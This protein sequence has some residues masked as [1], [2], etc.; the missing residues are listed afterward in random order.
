MGSTLSYDPTRFS[1]IAAATDL[2]GCR[3]RQDL[4]WGQL[5]A[6][7]GHVIYALGNAAD[8]ETGIA[9]HLASP[10]FSTLAELNAFCL[11]H[12]QD[13]ARTAERVEISGWLPERWFWQGR[14]A[15]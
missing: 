2:L 6:G 9:A 5:D 4:E 11:D 12:L 8:R 13:Y 10:W 1:A 7:G 14:V 3:V 15:A